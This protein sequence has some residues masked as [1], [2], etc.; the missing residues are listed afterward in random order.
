MLLL[1]MLVVASGEAE[2]RGG[3]YGGRSIGPGTGSNPRSYSIRPHSRRDGTSVTP[4]RRSTP[5]RGWRDN[6][7]T[8]GNVNPYTGRKGSRLHSR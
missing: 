3:R 5:N 4:H 8:K 1:C 2:A 7:S 6:W